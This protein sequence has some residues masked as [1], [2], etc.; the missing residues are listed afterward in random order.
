CHA[1]HPHDACAPFPKATPRASAPRPG[2]VDG[3]PP[4]GDGP[5]R[6]AP[7]TRLPADSPPKDGDLI[8]HQTAVRITSALDTDHWPRRP[9]T[10]VPPT[11]PRGGLLGIS[12]HRALP[13]RCDGTSRPP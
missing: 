9:T 6:A 10:C 4:T 7:P 1:E 2:E 5:S 12:G 13:T 11:R 3:S 8:R